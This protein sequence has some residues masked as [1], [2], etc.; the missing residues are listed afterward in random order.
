[1]KPGISVSQSGTQNTLISPVHKLS[2]LANS[3]IATKLGASKSPDNFD[4]N[5]AFE[6]LDDIKTKISVLP[7]KT[8]TLDHRHHNLAGV[9]SA[10]ASPSVAG[11]V[12]ARTLV[13]K[14]TSTASARVIENAS[15]KESP[16]KD[17][18]SATRESIDIQIEAA[19]RLNLP[20]DN[21]P[22]EETS[23]SR[24]A[25]HPLEGIINYKRPAHAYQTPTG[26]KS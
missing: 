17:K 16:T 7:A 25:L 4:I 6:E 26:G 11:R 9:N 15:D 12:V 24:N 13:S 23:K 5:K 3:R 1:M 10:G 18:E 21:H 14:K 22:G 20:N 8:N 2:S 19:E